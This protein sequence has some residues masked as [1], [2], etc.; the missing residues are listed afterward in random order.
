MTPPRE[1]VINELATVNLNNIICYNDEHFTAETQTCRPAALPCNRPAEQ[2][3]FSTLGCWRNTA[4][5]LKEKERWIYTQ[6]QRCLVVQ[7]ILNLLLVGKYCT[8]YH[9]W[10]SSLPQSFQDLLR[11]RHFYL[12]QPIQELHRLM[13][14]WPQ[15]VSP[16]VFRGNRK[17]SLD[18][19]PLNRRNITHRSQRNPAARAES[20][21]SLDY[22]PVWSRKTRKLGELEKKR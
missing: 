20:N 10:F 16:G 21:L 7:G 17:K 3:V 12:L 4:R 6:R 13:S 19:N 11:L 22:R 8:D 14:V 18:K 5:F 1:L 9:G 2:N 15:V